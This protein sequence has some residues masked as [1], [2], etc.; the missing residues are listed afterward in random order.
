MLSQYY[1]TAL[2]CFPEHPYTLA[3][4]EPGSTVPLADAKAT[5]PRHLGSCILFPYY[6]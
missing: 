1:K 6:L 5:A 4:F 2:L 3:G